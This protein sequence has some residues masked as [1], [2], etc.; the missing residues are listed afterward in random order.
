MCESRKLVSARLLAAVIGLSLCLGTPRS[1]RAYER[2]TH[3]V[4]GDTAV[5]RSNLDQI[6]KN[7]YGLTQGIESP[8]NGLSVRSWIGIG[9]NL[10]DVPSFRALNHFHNPLQPWSQA[11]GIGGQ[12]SIYWQQNSNQ[13]SGGTWSWPIA[14]QRFFESLTLPSKNDRE[15]ALADTARALGQIRIRDVV[16]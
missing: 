14:R 10:E 2:E 11:G 9:A 1:A 16:G 7:R 13:G 3:R 8:A 4:I 6:L 12:S 15:T 5:V